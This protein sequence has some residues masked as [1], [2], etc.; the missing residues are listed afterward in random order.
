MSGPRLAVPI[1]PIR[2]GDSNGATQERDPRHDADARRWR[3]DARARIGAREEDDERPQRVFTLAIARPVA[4][5]I[6]SDTEREQR[7]FD[8][9]RAG[10]GIPQAEADLHITAR[11][12]RQVGAMHQQVEE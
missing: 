10:D 2:P 7:E 6:K 5:E 8:D 12:E 4:T 9:Q 11:R 1:E 3:P